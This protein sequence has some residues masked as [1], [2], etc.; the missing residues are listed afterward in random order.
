MGGGRGEL[1]VYVC[2][3]FLF[4]LFVCCWDRFY[5]RGYVCY[6]GGSGGG[7]GGGSGGGLSRPKMTLCG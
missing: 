7:G 4:C 3:C 6:C 5:G 2:F 1:F